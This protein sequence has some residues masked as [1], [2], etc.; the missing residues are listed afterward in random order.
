MGEKDDEL[1]PGAWVDR[2]DARE[3]AQIIHARVYARWHADAGVPGHGQFL[4][5]DKLSR[6]LDAAL[7]RAS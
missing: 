4:L 5:I 2:L 1:Q 6:A 3:K 7:E